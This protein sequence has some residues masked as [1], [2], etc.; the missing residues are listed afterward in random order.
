MWRSAAFAESH[1]E[2]PH[3]HDY[4]DAYQDICPQTG[5][6]LRIASAA[7]TPAHGTTSTEYLLEQLRGQKPLHTPAY[8]S[9]TGKPLFSG[10]RYEARRSIEPSVTE[11]QS[12]FRIDAMAFETLVAEN[13]DDVMIEARS[14]LRQ[15]IE[16]EPVSIDDD[17]SSRVSM[18]EPEALVGHL[19]L[20]DEETSTMRRRLHE[21]V[22]CEQPTTQKT[23]S[24]ML[25]KPAASQTRRTSMDTRQSLAKHRRELAEL[26]RLS[27]LETK[28]DLR[29]HSIRQN[30]SER[31]SSENTCHRME[32]W[33]SE[34]TRK[35]EEKESKMLIDR[36]RIQT[37]KERESLLEAKK[38]QKRLEDQAKYDAE[39]ARRKYEEKERKRSIGL[40]KAEEF[41]ARSSN[42]QENESPECHGIAGMEVIESHLGRMEDCSKEK[43]GAKA[44]QLAAA[45]KKNHENQVKADR[46]FR[47]TT[48]SKVYLAWHTWHKIEMENK[49]LLQRHQ[50]RSQKMKDFLVALEKDVCEARREKKCEPSSTAPTIIS[51]SDI[52]R[53][54]QQSTPLAKEVSCESSPSLL[55][56]RRTKLKEIS[57]K[58][59]ANPQVIKPDLTAPHHVTTHPVAPA[60]EQTTPL[61]ETVQSLAPKKAKIKSLKPPDIL[62]QMKQRESERL[63]R[64]NAAEEKRKAREAEIRAEKEAV[65][66]QKRDAEEAERKRFMNQKLE[67]RRLAK[68]AEDEKLKEKEKRLLS[69]AKANAHNQ[70]RLAK[71]QGI[72][73]WKILVTLHKQDEQL[74]A[75]FRR[76]WDMRDPLLQWRRKLDIKWQKTEHAAKCLYDQKQTVNMWTIFRSRFTAQTELKKTAVL[77]SDHQRRKQVLGSWRQKTKESIFGRL[78]AEREKEIAADKLAMRLMPKRIL[79]KWF[80]ITREIKEE[81][82][83]E[84]R[85][86]QLRSRIKEMLS[87]STFE[88]KLKRDFTPVRTFH[89]DIAE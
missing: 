34:V 75:N 65:E 41:V 53:S 21:I 86:Q 89:S 36:D 64:K 60:A 79:R 50:E 47:I 8:S 19:M 6:N 58:S 72:L 46:H 11:A 18:R 17:V 12:E 9:V 22:G 26:Q 45:M 23:V 42:G 13:S 25:P 63:E 3:G 66:Q 7:T 29:H 48:I 33:E 71:A 68:L 44:E 83:R 1:N 30:D 51:P 43:R 37:R 76:K 54:T 10:D 57:F 39:L 56:I 61:K 4:D 67:E 69:L 74:A 24:T 49:K 70:K 15:W 78:Q 87:A 62:E 88:E 84:W 27:N 2:T 73:P 40:A 85:R 38:E 59:E 31:I 32:K 77:F 52:S 35:A 55:K 20:T 14:L 81:R 28:I 82:W 80:A 16:N 5:V